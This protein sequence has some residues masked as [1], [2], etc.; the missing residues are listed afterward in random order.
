MFSLRRILRGPEASVRSLAVQANEPLE[1][2]QTTVF[3]VLTWHLLYRLTHNEALGEE[4]PSRMTQVA[5]M[6]ALPGL[7]MA[8]YLFAPYH[9]PKAIGPRPYWSQVSDHYVYTVYAF[10]VMGVVTIFEWELLF[11][12][13]LDV[14]VLTT[15]P[16]AR[17]VL[18][19]A[20][21]LAL[22]TFLALALVG[23][24]FLGAMFF[25]AV[26]DLRWMFWHHVFAH[27]TA[28]AMAGT[29]AAALLVALQGGLLC[30]LGRRLFGLISPVVQAFAMVALLTV[31]F[32]TPLIAGNLKVL[33]G[34]GGAPVRW[35]P[36]F[37]F[38]GMYEFLL[39]GHAGSAMYGQL[40]ATA[41][42]ATAGALLLA[43]ATY[44]VAYAR[45]VRQLVEGA[46]SN[47][48]RNVVAS[49]VRRV[50]HAMLL[51]SPQVRAIYHFIS[52]TILRVPRLRLY[53]T[54][55][56]SVALALAISGA[57]LLVIHHGRIGFRFSEWGLRSAVPVLAFLIV[58]GMRTAMAAPVGVQ[59]SWV[60]LVVHGRPLEEHLRAVFL[61][62]SAAVSVVTLA[63][64]A[65]IKMLAPM[66]MHGWIEIAAQ[67]VLAVGVTVLLTQAFLL[68]TCEIPFTA[69]RVPSTR[70]LPISFVRYIVIFPA[71][72][73][74]V[75]NHEP[76]V[77][78][79]AMHLAETIALLAGIYTLLSW[80]RTQYL[81]QTDSNLPANDPVLVNRL[82]LQ[83]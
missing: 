61:W 51:R 68:R 74:F 24:N 22:G 29:F 16:I 23:T 66:V 4:I 73:F 34:M 37:W 56:A 19:G 44:P 11:P 57:L 3:E 21:M 33:F 52:Q 59:G 69:T 31:L 65:V 30:V 7:L 42:V 47:H 15:L 13:L 14:F 54:M 9:Q 41:V 50:L 78:A 75:V 72:V 12:D 25:P 64:V 46:A 10:V 5:Y 76:W 53:L 8:L 63:S 77:E 67:A 28:A 45:R 27:V 60:F 62:V 43:A 32:L 17:R 2:R 55:Y 20:R 38:L 83:E 80:M 6:L 1:A 70:D 48:R 36:P 79:S 82:G 71:F 58:A 49:T 35:F 40:A 26:A 18:L 81:T 39:H